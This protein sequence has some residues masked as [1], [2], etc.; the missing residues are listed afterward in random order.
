MG[1]RGKREAFSK[2]L[3]KTP[4]HVCTCSQPFPKRLSRP[5]FPAF[6]TIA[7]ASIG[8]ALQH[9]SDPPKRQENPIYIAVQSA[10]FCQMDASSSARTGSARAWRADLSVL[11]H[12]MPRLHPNLFFAVSSAEFEITGEL[13]RIAC[14]SEPWRPGWSQR[15][16]AFRPPIR[17]LPSYPALRLQRWPLRR[18]GRRRLSTSDRLACRPDRTEDCLRGRRDPRPSDIARQPNDSALDNRMTVRSKLPSFLIVPR[19]LKGVGIVGT[20][21]DV[22]FLLEDSD[23]L[24]IS[25]R[26]QES[27]RVVPMHPL[28]SQLATSLEGRDESANKRRNHAGMVPADRRLIKFGAHG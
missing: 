10:A 4:L 19:L 6:S 9:K 15:D 21:D 18:R 11:A 2:R 5:E 25:D 24:Y 13:F 16:G 26:L 3:W 7:A 1:A 17:I 27:L 20:G 14:S 12:E 23:G 22:E 28:E 8:H